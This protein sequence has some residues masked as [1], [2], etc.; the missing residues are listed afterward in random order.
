LSI[1]GTNLRWT[2]NAGDAVQEGDYPSKLFVGFDYVINKEN[3][4]EVPNT[5]LTLI[6][7]VNVAAVS[8]TSEG[9][10]HLVFAAQ[11]LLYQPPSINRSFDENGDAVWDVSYRLTYK[12]NIDKGGTK[13]G[14]NYFFRAKS[15][16]G[17]EGDFEPLYNAGGDQ[18]IPYETGDFTT[19]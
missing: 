6:G 3:L 7:K 10:N 14:W 15:G 16:V 19:I 9:L 4:A 17:E 11:T 1:D 18:Y 2:N 12:P 8:P 13:R 5:I